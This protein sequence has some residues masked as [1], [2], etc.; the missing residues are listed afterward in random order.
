M[1]VDAKLE[2]PDGRPEPETFGP[3]S[4]IY[5]SDPEQVIGT[6]NDTHVVALNIYPAYRP[7]YLMLALDSYRRQ[8]EPLDLEILEASWQ[9]LQQSQSSNVVIYNC[10]QEAGCSR[11]HKHMQILP[12]PDAKDGFSFFP[13][14]KDRNV[15]VP[16][17]HFIH[18]FDSEKTKTAVDGKLLYALYAKFLHQSRLALGIDEDDVETHCPHNV[19]LVKEWMVVIPRRKGNYNGMSANALGM[20]G[21][22]IVLKEEHFDVWAETGPAKVLSELGVATG[23]I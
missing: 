22:V 13:D 20:M 15:A 3:G 6:I 8:D 2:I 17:V 16:Y 21:M 9:F 11:Y 19:V 12:R 7:Q 1:T 10:G 14:A 23:S 5:R 18:Y 4:D